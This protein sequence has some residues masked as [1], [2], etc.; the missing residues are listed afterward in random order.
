MPI[1]VVL[2]GLW[3]PFREAIGMMLERL[4]LRYRI[5]NNAIVLYRK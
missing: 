5:E 3:M 2:S 1:G 4:N